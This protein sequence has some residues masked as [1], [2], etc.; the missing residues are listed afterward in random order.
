MK[1]GKHEKKPT[2][3]SI[4]ISFAVLIAL[5][6][7]GLSF[8]MNLTANKAKIQV[9]IEAGS[10]LPGVELFFAKPGSTG[11]FTTDMSAINT[12]EIKSIE[13]EL[14]IDGKKFT[15]LL[16]VEDTIPPTGK[17][18]ELHIFKG[19]E[20]EPEDFVTDIQDATKVVCSFASKPDANIPGWHDVTIMLTDEGENASEINSRL[21]VFEVADELVIEAG[22]DISVEAKD[23][24]CN[25]IEPNGLSIN[26]ND[27]IKFSS[28]GIYQVNL[29]SGKYLAFST[30]KI[31][32]TTPPVISGELDKWVLAGGTI[33]YRSGITV[34]DACDSNVQLVVDSSAVNLNVP[35]I[36]AVFYSATDASGNRAEAQGIVTVR[37]VDMDLVNGMADN[38]LSQIIR[39]GMSEYEKAKTIFYWVHNKM[40]YSANVSPR[41]I[42]QAAY[43]C[44]YRGTGDCYTYMAA[45]R[46]LLTRAGIDNMTVS[47][48]DAPVQHY[49]NIVNV[50]NG[51]H[52]FDASP[53]G[54]VSIDRKF[55]FTESQA[56]EFSRITPT[57][58]E[59]YKYDK[60]LVP[61][62]VE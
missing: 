22:E 7:A 19:G 13:I 29:K 17:P 35:G 47:R 39:G 15:S 9:V 3:K 20:I 37:A 11:K 38:I 49:W 2:K 52:H 45:S 53:N 36:Y 12:S 26:Q 57:E 5:S 1:K 31:V 56:R 42:A 24:I 28:P 55:M 40:K 59:N 54:Y 34:T 50:G 48:I 43:N 27:E 18:L 46:V 23:F 21:Y 32:D 16:I 41:E 10:D 30:V 4:I 62:V 6:I 8:F 61:E 44:F 14:E 51:W 58:Y 25:Y 60:S 33:A